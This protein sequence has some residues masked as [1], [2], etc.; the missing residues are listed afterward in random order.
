[1]TDTIWRYFRQ[2]GTGFVQRIHHDHKGHIEVL[3]KHGWEEIE[4]PNDDS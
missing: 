3:L 2:P 1:M 4:E